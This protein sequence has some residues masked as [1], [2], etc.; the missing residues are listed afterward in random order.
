MN[1]R[2]QKPTLYLVGFRIEPDIWEPQMYTIY[3]NDD[4]PILCEGQPI[5]FPRADHAGIALAKSDCGAASLGPAPTEL[6][7]VYDLRTKSC[8]HNPARRRI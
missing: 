5:L 8:R 4:R 2:D 7:T 1:S 3:V 6:Y